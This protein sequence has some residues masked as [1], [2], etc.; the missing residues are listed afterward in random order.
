[1]CRAVRGEGLGNDEPGGRRQLTRLRPLLPFANGIPSP[2]T[3]R[4]VF[5]ALNPNAF[6][7]CCIDAVSRPGELPRGHRRQDRMRQPHC[8]MGAAALGGGW[9]SA[10]G[11]TLG[12]VAT[13]QKSNEITT[14]SVLL[15]A[16]ELKGATVTIDVMGAQ[17][18]NRGARMPAWCLTAPTRTIGRCY[19]KSR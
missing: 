1:M 14:I 2:N 13:E 5:A 15:Q 9:C 4:R 10:T 6:E 7:Q 19:A 3:F 17:H 8:G 16:L 12:Q 18:E 11:L